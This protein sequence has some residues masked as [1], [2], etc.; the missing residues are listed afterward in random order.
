MVLLLQNI[1]DRMALVSRASDIDLESGI[2]LRGA[3]ESQMPPAWTD[4]LEEAQY[5][6]QRIRNKLR[7]LSAL[8]AKQLQRPTLDESHEE[9]LQ[10]ETLSQEISRVSFYKPHT[11]E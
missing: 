5:A 9:E 11:I 2:E 4:E 1:S 8:H 3:G 6:L 10:I 7:Q